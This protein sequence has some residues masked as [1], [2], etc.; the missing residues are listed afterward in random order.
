M[1]LLYELQKAGRTFSTLPRRLSTG[2]GPKYSDTLAVSWPL[3][4]RRR[5]HFALGPGLSQEDIER[6][7][8]TTKEITKEETQMK[9]EGKPSQTAYSS[10]E[11]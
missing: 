5:L 7:T 6:T 2:V 3:S 11:P 8:E 9:D 1:L 4:A 10:A